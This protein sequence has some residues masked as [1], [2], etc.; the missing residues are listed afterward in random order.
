[1]SPAS[2][3]DPALP[4][5]PAGAAQTLYFDGTSSIRHTV[6]LRFGD[7]LEIRDGDLVVSAW[8]YGDIRR[9]DSPHGMLRIGCLTSPVLARLEIRD[10]P[11]ATEVIA[12]CPHLDMDRI[13]QRGVG[14]IVGWSMAAI[15]SIVAMVLFGMPLVADRLTPLLPEQFDRHLGAIADGQIRT[16]LGGKVCDAPA[17]QAAF[18]KLV[19]AVRSAA[20]V[21]GAVDPVVLASPTPN[22]LA[23]PGGR[24]YLLKGLLDQAQ[25]ADEIAGVF[26]HELGHLK[27]RDGTRHLIH[28]GGASFLIG[29]LFGD[30]SGSGALIFASRTLVSSSYSRDAEQGAD[31][32]AIETM[33]WLGRSPKPMGELLFRV[34]GKQGDSPLSIVASHPLTEDRLARM[35]REDA[36]PIGPA[37]LNAAEWAALKSICD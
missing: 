1:M 2:S 27:H 16:L 24:I 21:K 12:R 18:A 32:S 9:A 17:G 19:D 35:G 11:T 28:N 23:L 7:L 29:L 33:H 36:A 8:S 31:T 3:P 30:I 6:E 20:M 13:G 4:P 22:A 10:D 37:L 5:T 26:A 34:T 15:V 14:A 25:D